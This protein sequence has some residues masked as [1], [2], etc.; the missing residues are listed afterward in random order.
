L[1]PLARKTVVIRHANDDGDVCDIDTCPDD[2]LIIEMKS[3]PRLKRWFDGIE[4]QIR[5]I[6]ARLYDDEKDI[7]EETRRALEEKLKRLQT[8][9]LNAPARASTT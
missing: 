1:P 5:K 8:I 9:D 7:S 6:F 3:T 2:T 4:T